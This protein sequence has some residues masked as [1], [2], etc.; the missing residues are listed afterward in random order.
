MFQTTPKNAIS[1]IQN[2]YD[3]KK[4]IMLWGS[5]GVGKSDA[6]RA[7]ADELG[8]EVVDIRASQMDPVDLRGIPHVDTDGTTSWATPSFFPQDKDSKGILFLDEINSAPPSVQ[9]ALYQLTLDRKLGE[10]TLPEGWVCIGAGNK[11]SDRGVTHR[12]PSPLANRFA[13]HIEVEAN[14]DEWIDWAAKHNVPPQIIAFLKFEPT[15]LYNF[16]PTRG[17]KAFATP[18]SWSYAAEWINQSGDISKALPML[19]ACLGEGVA[20][21]LKSFDTVWSRLPNIDDVLSGK[22]VDFDDS[23]PALCFAVATAVG[24]RAEKKNV[25]HAISFLDTLSPEYGVMGVKYMMSRDPMLAAEKAV[26]DWSGKNK[27]LFV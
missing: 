19:Q 17:D 20:V 26:L 6:V 14:L 25:K 7:A 27:N 24:H 8:I 21:A 18:R 15:N 1:T 16:D 4:P 3:L 11:D 10:Y 2:A 5:P 9:A 13:A 12:M 23:D 22:K